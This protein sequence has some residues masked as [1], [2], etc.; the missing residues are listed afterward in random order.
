MSEDT[1]RRFRKTQ[2]NGEQGIVCYGLLHVLQHD[3]EK[4]KAKVRQRKNIEKILGKFCKS[5]KADFN[6]T[7]KVRN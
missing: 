4:H 6:N 7:Q 1:K 2:S 3:S 5:H